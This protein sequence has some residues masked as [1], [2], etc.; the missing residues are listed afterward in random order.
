MK[1]NL[2][3]LLLLL[4][5]TPE[6]STSQTIKFAN[7][8]T[9][10]SNTY[11]ISGNNVF[12]LDSSGN[13]IWVKDFNGFIVNSTFSNK[14]FGSAFDGHYLYVLEMQG[15]NS[16]GIPHPYDAAILKLDTSGNVLSVTNANVFPGG[17]YDLIDIIPS[18]NNGVWIADD[19]APGFTHHGNVLHVDSTG[20]TDVTI[21]IWYG[22]VARIFRIR[23]LPDSNYVVCANHHPSSFPGL[24]FP[25]LLKFNEAGQ[26]LM[27]ADY[28]ISGG[29]NYQILTAE[30]MTIDN[31]GNYFFIFWYTDNTTDA[32]IG[33]KI[34]QNGNVLLSKLF[35]DLPTDP[36]Q[37]FEFNNDS[38]KCVINGNEIV[39][40]T[41]FNNPCI[42]TQNINMDRND[43]YYPGANSQ[44]FSPTTFTPS[45]GPSVTYIQPTYPDYC[46]NVSVNK[47]VFNNPLLSIFP[48]PTSGL[49]N[50]ETNFSSYSKIYITDITGQICFEKTFEGNSTIEI[51]S[52]KTGIY[53]LTLINNS[54]IASEKLIVN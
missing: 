5:I 12:K 25:A 48:N 24:S 53:F 50:I 7:T 26:I 19:Y 10:K 15:Y 13:S 44:N 29:S 14:L 54:A 31:S 3:L 40:D 28:T 32:Y 9:G 21:G 16:G 27:K 36:I 39:F 52:L 22:S 8:Y 1:I 18:W 51:T 49:I 4:F 34:S 33:V 42:I 23:N 41:S 46:A 6:I 2:H 37:S 30:A 43:N 17:S 35:P 47:I 20:L 45:S 38:I 11:G